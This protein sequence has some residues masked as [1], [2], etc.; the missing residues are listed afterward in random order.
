MQKY[1]L[2]RLK[3]ESEG[4]GVGSTMLQP[5]PQV[6]R[7]QVIRAHDERFVDNFLTGKL[8]SD[9]IKRIGFPWSLDLVFRTLSSSGGTLQAAVDA[10]SNGRIG[11]NLSGG[12]HHAYRD[13][14]SGYCVFND[15][16]IAA[17]HLMEEG[18]IDSRPG[19]VLVCDLD[20]HQGD[21]TASIFSQ[22][23]RVVTLSLHGRNNF[24]FRK[25]K[26]TVDVEFEDGTTDQFYLEQLEK[27]LLQLVSQHKPQVVFYQA[28]V[29]PLKGG[30]FSIRL[31]DFPPQT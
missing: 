6:R 2:L 28:G 11:G 24:P 30:T 10:V 18:Y 9:E 31:R 14:G 1:R 27:N 29:D 3:L 5:A 15:I 8:T 7:E 4:F 13:F 26:S 21:G 20:V 17:R 25:Q 19:A 23:N 16:A 22:D 12:T